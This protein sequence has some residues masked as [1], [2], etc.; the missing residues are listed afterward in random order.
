MVGCEREVADVVIGV[1]L[2]VGKHRE[3]SPSYPYATIIFRTQG[4]K[5]DSSFPN[6][7]G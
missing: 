3:D 4:E 1:G 7:S 6:T 2:A 5:E